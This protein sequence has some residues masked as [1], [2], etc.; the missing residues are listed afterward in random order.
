MNT[1]SDDIE[2]TL[3]TFLIDAASM[4]AT[5][6]VQGEK[7]ALL[8]EALQRTAVENQR[9]R[10]ALADMMANGVHQQAAQKI[11]EACRPLVASPHTTQPS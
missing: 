9:A 7:V 5:L 10:K 4:R 6:D 8:T 1:M 3:N 11:A 2:N